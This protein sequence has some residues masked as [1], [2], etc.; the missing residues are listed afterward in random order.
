LTAVVAALGE[1]AE[2]D[3]TLEKLVGLYRV[4]LPRLAVA[5]RGWLERLD[6]ASDGPTIRWLS[7]VVADE[8]DD[9]REGEAMVQSFLRSPSDVARAAAQ[10]ARLESLVP[11]AA[12]HEMQPK[13]ST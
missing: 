7:F 6:P 4:V 9:W 2:P 1:A 12:L 10:Q 3:Q 11:D 5:Y 13:A 8:L